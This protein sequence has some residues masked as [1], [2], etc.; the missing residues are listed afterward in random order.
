[1]LHFSSCHE[2]VS[3]F[4]YNAKVEQL[5]A[6]L[7]RL[8]QQQQHQWSSQKRSGDSDRRR[9]ITRTVIISKPAEYVPLKPEK[10]Q[11]V[12]YLGVD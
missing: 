2:H 7:R 6:L 11:K 10:W 3:L 12:R 9:R 4:E 1:V 8:Q 5:A